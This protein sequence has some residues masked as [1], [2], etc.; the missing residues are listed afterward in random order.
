VAPDCDP[1]AAVALAERLRVAISGLSIE[2]RTS[3]IKVT[4][5]IGIAMAFDTP[6]AMPFE[7]LE[8]ADQALYRAKGAGRDAAWIWDPHLQAPVSL[9]T[10]RSETHECPPTR[11]AEAAKREALKP[12]SSLVPI[13][14][15]CR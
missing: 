5:S 13:T 2:F 4:T 10:W 3:R 6:Q 9:E 11:T 15:T 1:T 12:R 14:P 7:T 8:H